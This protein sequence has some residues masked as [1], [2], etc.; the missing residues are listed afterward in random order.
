MG[1]PRL[2]P[3]DK[4]SIFWNFSGPPVPVGMAS[5]VCSFRV[6]GFSPGFPFGEFLG[7]LNYFRDTSSGRT[8]TLGSS[9][10]TGQYFW[11]GGQPR[12]SSGHPLLVIQMAQ[13][14]HCMGLL[15]YI[16]EG[17]LDQ[18]LPHWRL[19][20]FCYH[21]GCSLMAYEG[22][23]QGD[24]EAT[25]RQ[26]LFTMAPALHVLCETTHMLMVLDTAWDTARRLKH[27]FIKD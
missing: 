4:I 1:S 11:A 15:S 27:E 13:C 12:A 5:Q 3:V 19:Q 14:H 2:Q 22:H 7:N 20:H 6:C 17:L 25:K 23:M 24:D 16:R 21:F 18:E 9:L 26:V 8:W 10:S